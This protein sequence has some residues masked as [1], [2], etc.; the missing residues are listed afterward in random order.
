MSERTLRKEVVVAGPVE[1]VWLAWTTVEGAR[2]FFAPEAKIE[3]KPGG[4]YELYFDLDEPPG[5]RGSEGCTVLEV[6][7]KTH[8][9][10]SWNFPPHLSIRDAKTTVSVDIFPAPAEKARVVLEQTGW[11]SG[12]EWDA[13]FAYF[14]RAWAMVLRFLQHRFLVGPVDW[15]NPPPPPASA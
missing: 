4:A 11:Q 7:P 8:L 3:A 13:G 2:T 1:A 10:V 5:R 6:V 9:R 14:D 12:P 15:K